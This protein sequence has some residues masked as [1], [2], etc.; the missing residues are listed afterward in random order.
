MMTTN[1]MTKQKKKEKR[2][3]LNVSKVSLQDYSSRFM[4]L[5]KPSISQVVLRM[6]QKIVFG[7]F[8]DYEQQA[9]DLTRQG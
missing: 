5:M 1:R 7:I 6:C 2:R 3:I 8:N 4:K 9:L